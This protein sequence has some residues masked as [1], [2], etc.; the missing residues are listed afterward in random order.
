LLQQAGIAE[1][2]P[3]LISYKSWK[4]RVYRDCWN[5]IQQHW[6]AERFIRVTDD[7]E[8]A[9]FFAINQLT[10][11]PRTGQPVLQNSLGELDVD[12]IM[13]EGPDTVNMQADSYGVMQSL[14]PQFIQQFP[15]VALQLAPLQGSVKKQLLDKIKQVQSQPPPPD[16]K[17]QA[18]QA[19]MQLQAQADQQ[20]AQHEQM[21][22]AARAQREEAKILKDHELKRAIAIDESQRKRDEAEANLALKAREQDMDYNHETRK[23]MMTNDHE[24]NRRAMDFHHES[25]KHEASVD[26]EKT[27]AATKVDGEQKVRKAQTSEPLIEANLE[28]LKGLVDKMDSMTKALTAPKK[29]IRDKAGRPVGVETAA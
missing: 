18:M 25:R 23:Q 22:E 24:T 2:G 5:I 3:Y 1:L 14:G 29:I 15:E 12:I 11:D 19:Q 9:Q 13:D 8:L 17:V 26:A 27:K 7:Y 6:K 20:A 28:A 10:M 16:P 4:T 21:V